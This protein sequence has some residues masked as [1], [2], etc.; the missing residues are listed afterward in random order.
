MITR[1]AAVALLLAGCALAS[2]PDARSADFFVSP[3]GRDTWS[4]RQAA[5]NAARTDGPFATLARA[6]DAVRALRKQDPRRARPVVV[7]LRGGLYPLAEPVVFDHRDAAGPAA[8]LIIGAYADETPVLSGGRRLTGWKIDAKGWWH[9]DVPDVKAGRWRFSQL[10]V[11][12][13]R[14]Y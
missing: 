1:S 4:G 11:N 10:F 6:R 9:L 2:K 12:G 7:R 8:P 13:S 3:S 14:R 5:P